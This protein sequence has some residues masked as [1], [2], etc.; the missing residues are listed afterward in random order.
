MNNLIYRGFGYSIAFHALVVCSIL[1]AG[2]LLPKITPP[3]V[4]DFSIESSNY[5]PL[6]PSSQKKV[7]KPVPHPPENQP[8]Q[9]ESAPVKK[10]IKPVEPQEPEITEPVPVR[11]IK[12]SSTKQ[13]FV[14]A[15]ARQEPE[16]VLQITKKEPPTNKESMVEPVPEFSAKLPS[17]QQTPA[18]RITTVTPGDETAAPSPEEQYLQINFSYIRD[19]VARNT[20]Y[21]NIARR[22]GWE[23]KVLVTFTIC[24]DGRVENI[25]V[26]QSCGHKALDENAVKTIKR[27]APFPK[28]PAT[29]EVTLPITYKLH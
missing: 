18:A 12:I 9:E 8:Q 19:T 10:E 28:P 2:T 25:R 1:W 15:T 23:G 6:P 29:A 13:K 7:A 26:I 24:D 4:I 21:P 14:I 5:S 17:E 22:M 11:T 27:S 3:L 16:P 20:S